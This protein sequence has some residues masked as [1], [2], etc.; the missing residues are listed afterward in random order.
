MRKNFLTGL[1]LL[2][3]VLVTILILGYI[4]NFLT[5]PFVN[6]LEDLL[7]IGRYNQELVSLHQSV[8]LLMLTRLII[9]VFIFFF[10]VLIGF[11]TKTFFMYSFFRFT[12][13]LI[14]KIP[15]INKVYKAIQE[16]IQTLF[17]TQ[18]NSFKQVVLVP[19]PSPNSLAVGFVTSTPMQ[20]S[21]DPRID[22]KIPV[23]VAGALNPSVGFIIFFPKDKIQYID[24]KIEDAF[25]LLVSCGIMMPSKESDLLSNVN[26]TKT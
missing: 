23:F 3:P 25:K 13:N 4:V 18:S 14:K 24:M 9:L 16:V 22:D 21:N 12:D 20:T 8:A 6:I 10:I 19:Y 5:D 1:V 26:E 15:I 2:L 7:N 17:S 11:L